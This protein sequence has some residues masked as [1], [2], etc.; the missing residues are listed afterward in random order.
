M[1]RDPQA[2]EHEGRAGWMVVLAAGF[3]PFRGSGGLLPSRRE[4]EPAAPRRSR[5]RSSAPRPV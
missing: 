2:G 1:P 4:Q 3:N 5:A